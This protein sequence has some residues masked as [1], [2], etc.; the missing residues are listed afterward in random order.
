[1]QLI[2][3]LLTLYLATLPNFTISNNFRFLYRFLKLIFIGVQLIYNVVLVSA[4]QQ[5]ESAK[6]YIY[7]RFF[8]FFSHIG[9][10][11]VLSRVP[12]AIPQV[13]ISYLFYI[14]TV[15]SSI[16][17]NSFDFSFPVLFLL[18]VFLI[19][20]TDHTLQDNVEQRRRQQAHWS[21]SQ[22]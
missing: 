4:V 1:M 21:Y 20:G 7:P 15:I 17:N 14:Q 2:F 12:C 3:C 11:R 18:F 6:L 9:H 19:L 5:S 8:R 10:Y 22:V 16:N 13:L